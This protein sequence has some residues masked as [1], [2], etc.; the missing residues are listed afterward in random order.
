MYSR[1]QGN[2]LFLILIA[3]ALFA[4]LSYAVTQSSRSGGD[5][6][7]ETGLLNSA[8]IA[9]SATAMQTAAMRMTLS[10]ISTSSL[11]FTPPADFGANTE[12]YVFHPQGGGAT[13]SEVPAKTMGRSTPGKW[14]VN[15]RFNISAV[16]SPLADIIAFL[17]GIPLETCRDINVRNGL[18]TGATPPGTP[19]AFAAAQHT[20][21]NLSMSDADTRGSNG[22]GNISVNAA[23]NDASPVSFHANYAGYPVGCFQN[24]GTDGEYV[25]YFTLVER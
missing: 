7:R 19:T 25:Y 6:S 4:A 24:G 23:I 2:V 22:Q 17:P 18:F 16:G 1:N 13:Y 15:G 20:V 14:V 10:G 9:Q 3:V 11:L 12:R 5:S 8:S 21:Y